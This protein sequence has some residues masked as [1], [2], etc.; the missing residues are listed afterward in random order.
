MENSEVRVQ[1]FGDSYSVKSDLDP[2]YM[3][4]L[5]AHVDKKLTAIA[6]GNPMMEKY[7]VAVLAALAIA[8]ELHTLRNEAEGLQEIFRQQTQSCLQIVERA[9]ESSEPS[10][11]QKPA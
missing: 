7:R 11:S 4:T 2:E 6:S 8:D 5:A 9:L 1:I 3:Q 10:H